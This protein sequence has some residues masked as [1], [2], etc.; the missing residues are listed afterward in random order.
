M[1]EDA[2]KESGWPA[3]VLQ[4][5]TGP[6]TRHNL[7]NWLGLIAAIFFVK[8]MLF[9]QYTVPTG[10][11]EPTI[12]GAPGLF[13]GDR[14]L[15][16]KAAFGL[17]I[18]LTNRYLAQ[19]GAPRRW[20]IVVF[21]NP[22]FESPDRVLIKRIVALPGESVL[23]KNGG[24]HID[25]APAPLPSSMPS[26]LFYVNGFEMQLMMQHP[27]FEPNP[28]QREFL[29]QVWERY[30]IRYASEIAPGVLPEPG[31]HQVPP[32]HY[33][34]LGDNSVSPGQFSVDGRVWGWLPQELLL[35]RAIGIWW[36]WPH[37]R[38]FTGWT[39]TP[40]GLGLLYGIPA[41]FLLYEGA[42]WRRRRNRKTTETPP[43]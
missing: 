13:H 17:R 12:Q 10:S 22:D 23:I 3:R 26:E 5:I 32:G 30:P 15:V 6:W 38:D 14:V 31:L 28:D 11:M 40:A 29:Q 21:E 43:A 39:R 8:T 37:R 33:F 41:A 1:T 2:P 9:D 16:N 20:D 27:E 7:L 4:A 19:W 36:P 35:G 24:I 25:G 18:P 42:L 34:A